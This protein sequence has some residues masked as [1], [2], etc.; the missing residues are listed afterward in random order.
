MNSEPQVPPTRLI[1]GPGSNAPLGILLKVLSV[2]LFVT[3]FACIKAVGEAVPVGE[4][5]FFRSVFALP[6]ILLWVCLHGKLVERLRTSDP[7]GH[8][9]R[10]LAGVSAM[11]LGF[12]AIGLLPF[13]EVVAIGYAAPLFA[14]LLAALLLG[15]RLRVYRLGAIALGLVGV[16]LVLSPRLGLLEEGEATG[17][18]QLIGASAALAAAILSAFAQVF[19]RGLV[20]TETTASVAF[21][22]TVTSTVCALA[23]LPFGWVLPEPDHLA[24]LV[25]AGV[26][27]GTGQI[28]LT[29]SYRHAELAVIAPFD[30]ASILLSLAIGWFVFTEAPTTTMLGGAVLV[31]LAGL[32]ILRREHRLGLERT[33]ARASS[34]TQQ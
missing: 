22:F 8:L 2:T 9:R 25:A 1:P 31:I 27:G 23:T 30:Y 24:L 19:A 26:L 3:M 17:R 21:W 28:L 7:W 29:E 14:T 10:G 11:S 6:P 33:R 5:V 32:V 15:E 4:K 12:L 13:S 18:M 34:P 20:A 16:L